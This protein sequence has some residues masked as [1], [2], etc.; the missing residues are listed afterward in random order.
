MVESLALTDVD[1]T[2]IRNDPFPVE[3]TNNE[4]WKDVPLSVIDLYTG[5]YDM[6]K[7]EAKQY[8]CTYLAPKFLR[9]LSLSP[10]F[11]PMYTRIMGLEAPMRGYLC[12][13]LLKAKVSVRKL[14]EW[15]EFLRD[16]KIK[17]LLDKTRMM[18]LNLAN[19]ELSDGAKNDAQSQSQL[20]A[21]KLKDLENKMTIIEQ[22]NIAILEKMAKTQETISHK[23]E[24]SDKMLEKMA[25]TQET[26]S[27]KP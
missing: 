27:Q 3:P 11:Q 19:L 21:E 17:H 24:A 23:Q 14:K 12:Y 1:L 15:K 18:E 8:T 16:R 25:Q 2:H 9:L 7:Y 5:T 4:Q 13:L 26:I 10:E 6:N 22:A 20:D